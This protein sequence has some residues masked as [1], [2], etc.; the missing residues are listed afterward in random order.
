M[1]SITACG[2]ATR[3]HVF[4][5]LLRH[6]HAGAG[7]CVAIYGTDGL[8]HMAIRIARATG[9]EVSVLNPVISATDRLWM[10]ADHYFA[11]NDP[12]THRALEG[13]FDLI[14]CTVAEADI[15]TCLGLLKC[16][17]ALLMLEAQASPNLIQNALTFCGLSDVMN[18]E[19]L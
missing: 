8:A 3:P 10:G 1:A 2:V 5:S 17:G 19:R 6:R 16:D 13:A 4:H 9:A 15:K 11:T 14:V 12:V 7:K 18:T